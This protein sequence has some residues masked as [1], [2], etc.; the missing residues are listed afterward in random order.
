MLLCYIGAFQL[1]IFQVE[2]FHEVRICSLKVFSGCFL[3]VVGRFL[4]TVGRFRLFLAHCRSFHRP[5]QIAPPMLIRRARARKTSETR[6]IFRANTFCLVKR[7]KILDLQVFSQ[8]GKIIKKLQ[9]IPNTMINTSVLECFDNVY[10][11]D[12]V[13]TTLSIHGLENIELIACA[14]TGQR[15]NQSSSNIHDGTFDK[16]SQPPK[17][18]DVICSRKK[19]NLRYL[20]GS[21][22]CFC[23]LIH[24]RSKN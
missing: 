9:W 6:P 15:C 16:N 11:S 13:K 24:Y 1:I 5:A 8:I 4:F 22:T 14:R 23:K 18:K 2:G 7:K 3:L 12:G 17:F 10:I 20:A 19:I 21:R